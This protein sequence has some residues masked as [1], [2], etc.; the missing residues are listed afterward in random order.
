MLPQKTALAAVIGA[1]LVSASVQG[2]EIEFFLPDNDHS[3]Y[4]SDVIDPTQTIYSYNGL[5][6]ANN[7]LREKTINFADFAQLEAGRRYNLTAIQ[8]NADA[9][10]TGDKDFFTA[11]TNGDDLA[12][13]VGVNGQSDWTQ[14]A[15]GVE[16]FDPFPGPLEINRTENFGLIVGEARKISDGTTFS[17]QFYETFAD[18]DL[19]PDAR[20][21][22]VKVTLTLDELVPILN[23]TPTALDFG[24][25]RAG[26]GTTV[27][28]NIQISNTGEAGSLL[29]G[30]AGA[31]SGDAVFSGGPADFALETTDPAQSVGY[32]MTAAGSLGGDT[33]GIQ[34]LGT[35]T[36]TDSDGNTVDVT[37]SGTTVGPIF[38]LAGLGTSGDIDLGTV[39]AGETG[40]ASQTLSNLFGSDFGNLTDLTLLNVD[41]SGPDAGFFDLDGIGGGEVVSATG[42]LDFLV[43][44]V[45]DA[46]RA[47]NATLTFETDVNAALGTAGETYSFTLLGQGELLDPELSVNGP[48]DFGNVRIGTTSAELLATATNSGEAGSELKNVVFSGATGAFGP[49][50]ASLPVN[51]MD[52]ESTNRGY[53]FTPGGFGAD[54]DTLVVSADDVTNENIVLL[55]NGVGPIFDLDGL[56]TGGT[57]DLGEVEIGDSATEALT[58]ANL[59][60]FDLDELTDLTI[61]NVGISGA[62]AGL[63]SLDGIS[64]GDV[65]AGDSLLDFLVGFAPTAVGSFS[66]T[67]TFLTDVNAPFGV[68]GESYSFTLTGQGRNPAPPPGPN[69][70]PV[71]A[72]ATLLLLG[73]GLLGLGATRRRNPS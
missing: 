33:D 3:L 42:L 1:L 58:L 4:Q 17:F 31:A 16:E 35:A 38:D 14:L 59:F 73:L 20:L 51:L 50:G 5:D 70:D 15:P 54:T 11:F 23:V 44:F 72:P 40:S 47:Y 9:Y 7:S 68:A 63:F 43:N 57:I 49:G 61:L 32:R 36:V 2:V 24:N 66:A 52:G 64:A 67:L 55:G 53:T 19:F 29:S 60:N 10:S 18:T 13:E 30:T 8:F 46:E 71:P 39:V 62:D 12:V 6:D 45:P 26:S 22:D 27:D 25:V 37:M 28:R 34:H 21:E 56:G 69:P 65:I 48:I 41:I